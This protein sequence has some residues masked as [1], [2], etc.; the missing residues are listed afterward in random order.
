MEK[1][2]PHVVFGIMLLSIIVSV[3]LYKLYLEK[4]EKKKPGK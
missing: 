3:Y 1:L 4:G 2:G